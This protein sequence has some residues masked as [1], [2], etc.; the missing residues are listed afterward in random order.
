[1]FAS[2][3]AADRN[4]IPKP[5]TIYQNMLRLK[6]DQKL[7]RLAMAHIARLRSFPRFRPTSKGPTP[8]R[9]KIACK[10]DNF[11]IPR[12]IRDELR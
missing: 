5:S 12:A 2:D 1:M 6:Y 11:T 8:N 7:F 3:A 9:N 4:T 10:H